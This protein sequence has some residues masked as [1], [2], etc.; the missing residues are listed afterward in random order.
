MLKFCLLPG[1]KISR[2]P[3][4]NRFKKAFCKAVQLAG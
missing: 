4:L 1:G 2:L 3:V